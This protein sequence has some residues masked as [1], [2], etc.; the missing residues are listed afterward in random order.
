MLREDSAVPDEAADPLNV[1]ET[2]GVVNSYFGKSGSLQD[3]L[4]A[5]LPHTG[6]IY[7]HDNVHVFLLI[8]KSAGTQVLNPL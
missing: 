4:A 3:E 1:D 7:K 5:K 6:P 2:I 8:E